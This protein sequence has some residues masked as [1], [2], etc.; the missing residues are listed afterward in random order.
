LFTPPPENNY[1]LYVI[2]KDGKNQPVT[3]DVFAE[4]I[5]EHQINRLKGMESLVLAFSNTIHYFETNHEP[6]HASGK[7]FELLENLTVNY[8]MYSR[9][10]KIIKPKL[11][12]VASNIN[13]KSRRVFYN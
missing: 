6:G 3:I 11:I 7:N 10:E 9:G 13:T 1:N 4:V 8:L 12:L 5:S 2:Y